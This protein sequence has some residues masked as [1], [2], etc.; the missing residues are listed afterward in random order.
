[1]INGY[2]ICLNEWL[3]DESIKTELRLLIKISSLTAEKG[4]CY[5]S[6]GFFADYF[7]TSDVT[8]SKQIKK[9]EKLNYIE[10]QYEKRGAEILKRFIRLKKTLTDDYQKLKPTIKENFKENITSINNISNNRVN[11]FTPPTLKEVE[12]FVREKNINVDSHKFFNYFDVSDWVDSKGNKVKNWKQKLITW[13]KKTNANTSVKEN[14]S[15]GSSMQWW[16][17]QC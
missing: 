2:G 1:M 5:A 11:K 9:L 7:S 15:V 16:N 3:E 13:D 8:I 6:N 10:I 12:D 14:E 4:F 17:S